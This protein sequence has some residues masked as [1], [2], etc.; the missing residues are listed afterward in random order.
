MPSPDVITNQLMQ[1]STQHS[2]LENCLYS[3]VIGKKS[4]NTEKMFNQ[5]ERSKRCCD[6][7]RTGGSS[8]RKPGKSEKGA[9]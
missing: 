9:L 2:F 4:T 3:L 8:G 5:L 1:D 7:Q 6:P